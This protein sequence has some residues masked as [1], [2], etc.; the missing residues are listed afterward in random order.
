ML[1]F[2]AQRDKIDLYQDEDE[3]D[4]LIKVK[5]TELIE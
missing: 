1:L 3:V 2:L 5:E 4:I